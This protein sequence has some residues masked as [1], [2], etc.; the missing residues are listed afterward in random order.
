MNTSLIIRDAEELKSLSAH[1]LSEVW[2]V[3]RTGHSLPYKTDPQ[4]Y[5]SKVKVFLD[6]CPVDN[7]APVTL[8]RSASPKANPA[9]SLV[10]N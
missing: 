7:P 4:G 6:N 1:Q 3:P 2:I 8:P 9:K 5:I 10:T